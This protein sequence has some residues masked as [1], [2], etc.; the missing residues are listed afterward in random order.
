VFHQNIHEKPM[1][2]NISPKDGL[3]FFLISMHIICQ[4]FQHLIFYCFQFYFVIQSKTKKLKILH[5]GL[6]SILYLSCRC[7]YTFF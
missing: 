2:D 4:E 1:K 6:Y 3:I 7:R 5:S